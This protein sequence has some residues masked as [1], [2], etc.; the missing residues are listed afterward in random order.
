MYKRDIPVVQL[1]KE[2][3]TE[4]VLLEGLL[5]NEEIK[6]IF[7]DNDLFLFRQTFTK[8]GYNIRNEVAHGMYLPQEYSAEKTLLVFLCILRLAKGIV[9]S[10]C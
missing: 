1:R 3:D 2:G 6:N 8:D 10:T 5:N 7:N 9:K 4:L